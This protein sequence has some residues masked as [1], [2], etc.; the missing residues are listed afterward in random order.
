MD[1]IKY[2][3]SLQTSFRYENSKTC[4]VLLRDCLRNSI[5]NR[6]LLIICKSLRLR[7]LT[8][9]NSHPNKSF[10]SDI[11]PNF[12][13]R[14]FNVC[15]V[16]LDVPLLDR[17]YPIGSRFFVPVC[18]TDSYSGF[19][20]MGRVMPAKF[21][22]TTECRSWE[23]SP[24]LSRIHPDVRQHRYP[25]QSAGKLYLSLPPRI[26]CQQNPIQAYKNHC[27]HR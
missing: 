21:N 20:S 8:Y 24:R 19:F 26:P 7:R 14:R 4:I 23:G 27:L 13:D 6:F 11:P 1:G 3:I 9:R 15:H 5:L 17:V 22:A 18:T 25:R 10:P 16:Q 12:A 2:S